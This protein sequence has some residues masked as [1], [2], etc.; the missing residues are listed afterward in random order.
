MAKAQEMHASVSTLNLFRHCLLLVFFFFPLENAGRGEI[1]T[2]KHLRRAW[3]VCPVTKG[4]SYG[5]GSRANYLRSL[6]KV[7]RKRSVYDFVDSIHHS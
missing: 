4:I 7:K 3:S 5:G 2:D 1:S 6:I